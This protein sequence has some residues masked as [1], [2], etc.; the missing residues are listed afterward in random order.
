MKKA[1]VILTAFMFAVAGLAAQETAGAGGQT[2]E[3]KAA[4][5][6][7]YWHGRIVRINKDKSTMDVR[8]RGIER[9][10]VYSDSTRWTMRNKP[11]DQSEFKEGADVV[12]RGHYDEQ[13][14]LVATRI[15]LRQE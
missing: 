4:A 2:K 11:A 14:R 3:K 12:V 6:E 5:G 7:A 10:V 15:D 8:G 1:L 13:N 9:R